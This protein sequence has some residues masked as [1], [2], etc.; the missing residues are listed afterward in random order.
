MLHQLS[1]ST[2]SLPDLIKAGRTQFL[3]GLC[4][5]DSIYKEAMRFESL[6]DLKEDLDHLLMFGE[7]GA[8]AFQ[9][10]PVFDKYSDSDDDPESFPD[11]H[12][13][14]TINTMPQ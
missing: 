11:S 13:G 6:S 9:V 1:C 12:L 3:F 8:T 4:N 5:A 7:E 2:Q 10:V 14:L